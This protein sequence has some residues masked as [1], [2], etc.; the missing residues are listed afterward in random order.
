[1]IPYGRQSLDDD[2]IAAVLAV[3]RSDWLTQ[4]PAIE[5]FEQEIC[6]YTGA[7]FAVAVSSGT[8][9]LHAAA[10]AAGLGSGDLVVTSPLSFV[11][12]ANAGR[13]VGSHVG[14]VDIDSA[15]LNTDT[16]LVPRSADA[17]VAVHFAGLPIDLGALAVRPRVV[18]EDAAHALGAVTADGP[19]GNCAHSDMC[20][21]SFHPVKAITTGEG[22]AVT[23]NDPVLADR[24]RRFRHHGIVRTPEVSPVAYDVVELG[25]NGRLTDIQAALG[26]S[27]MGK[28]DAFVDR[29]NEVAERYRSLLARHPNIGVP[30]LPSVGVRHAYHLFAV[31][32]PH[33][34]AVV[35]AM[36]DRGIGVQVHY[37]SIQSFSAYSGSSADWPCLSADAACSRLLSI[38]VFPTIT[39][40]EVDEVVDRLVE[41]VA[42]LTEDG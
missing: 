4:G 1:M 9:A 16:A 14:F 34:D 23:T 3:L 39:D 8:V 42:S 36:R 28:L 13:Y 41:V 24:L 20:C 12:S 26:R 32:V 25:C 40:D 33:R 7:R 37:P 5:E 6:A 2:D 35:S 29:R 31:Q 30:P 19:V 22:G 18:I 11:A 10:H 21:F 27:Q 38:P 17:F 15:T